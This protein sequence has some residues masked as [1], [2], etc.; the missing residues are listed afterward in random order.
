M[1][2]G[3]GIK[4]LAWLA[5]IIGVLGFFAI[6]PGLASFDRSGDK[7]GTRFPLVVTVALLVADLFTLC[8]MLVIELQDEAAMLPRWLRIMSYVFTMGSLAGAVCFIVCARASEKS[9]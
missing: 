5:I 7:K 2:L 8:T 1:S 9:A 4:A 6:T 3:V